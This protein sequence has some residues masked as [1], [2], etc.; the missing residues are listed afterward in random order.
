MVCFDHAGIAENNPK[1][2]RPGWGFRFVREHT[3]MAGIFV[4]PTRSHWFRPP[5]VR[6]LCARLAGTGFFRPYGGVMTYGGS[7][8]GYAA[9]VDLLDVPGRIDLNI[10][11]V[12]HGIPYHLRRMGLLERLFADIAEHSFDAATWRQLVRA[13]RDLDVYKARIGARRAVIGPVS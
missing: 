8:G 12:G 13:R 4:K 10:P 11:F 6:E 3:D 2:T 9:H 1:R 5:G 7:M